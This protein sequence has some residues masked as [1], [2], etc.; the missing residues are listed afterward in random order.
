MYRGSKEVHW[1]VA[2]SNDS[3]VLWAACRVH[4]SQR[5]GNASP[6]LAAG[7]AQ[8]KWYVVSAAVSG[9]RDL[10]A[11]STCGYYLMFHLWLLF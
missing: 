1:I 6:L 8:A 5:H 4:S 2:R 9:Q 11:C 10:R 3:R 7:G